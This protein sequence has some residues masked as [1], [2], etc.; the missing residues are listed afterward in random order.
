[1]DFCFA[2]YLV[3][4]QVSFSLNEKETFLQLTCSAFSESAT[5]PYKVITKLP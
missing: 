1:M 3:N 4:T 5:W 2:D